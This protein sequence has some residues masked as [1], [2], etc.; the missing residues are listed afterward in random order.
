MTQKDWAL[1]AQI[2]PFPAQGLGLMEDLAL[3]IALGRGFHQ[4]AISLV[5]AAHMY[6]GARMD[7][8]EFR[9]LCRVK[10]QT[11]HQYE[12]GHGGGAKGS[13]CLGTPSVQTMLELHSVSL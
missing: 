13:R 6:A 5:L 2:S 3:L 7:R 10:T 11:S 1:G 4:L 9:G 8:L 12:R